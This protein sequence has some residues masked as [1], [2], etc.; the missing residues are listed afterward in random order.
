MMF[1]LSFFLILPALALTVV[2]DPGHGGVD[3]GASRGS[4]VE[5]KIVF[6]IA[7]KIQK[8]FKDHPE[9]KILLTRSAG[10]GISLDDRVRFAQE[11][12]ADLFLSLHANSSTSAQVSGLEYYFSSKKPRTVLLKSIQRSEQLSLV[13]LIK[14]DLIEFGKTKQ[15]LAFSQTIQQQAANFLNADAAAN[16]KSTKSKIRRAPFFVIENTEMPA[17]LVEVGF[18]SNVREARKLITSDYQD[19]LARALSA[20]IEDY[21]SQ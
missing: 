12:K 18:I 19:N 20:A 11:N 9:I 3:G 2:V 7:E 8:N 17:V 5:S 4:F 10:K 14:K 16:Q 21:S 15:S 6:E 13:E 1:L